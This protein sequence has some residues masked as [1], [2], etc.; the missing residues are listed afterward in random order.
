MKTNPRDQSG[1]ASRR[2]II[3][4]GDIEK[5]S[6]N[7]ERKEQEIEARLTEYEQRLRQEGIVE[8]N[9][10]AVEGANNASVDTGILVA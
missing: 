4:C 8:V 5:R 6:S 10:E 1:F 9:R 7:G 3:S 2:S